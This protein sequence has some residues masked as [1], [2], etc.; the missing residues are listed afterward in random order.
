MDGDSGFTGMLNVTADDVTDM[1]TVTLEGMSGDLDFKVMGTVDAS[2]DEDQ[3]MLDVMVKGDAAMGYTLS[4]MG[5][6]STGYT[7]DVKAMY[8]GMMMS[9]GTATKVTNG[10]S[11]SYIDGVTMDYTDVDLIDSSK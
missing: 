6:E 7:G 2:G 4:L 9:F 11:I 5:A 10:L 8:E 1:G 3:S